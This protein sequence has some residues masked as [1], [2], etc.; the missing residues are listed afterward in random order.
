MGSA[1]VVTVRNTPI[2]LSWKTCQW[3]TTKTNAALGHLFTPPNAGIK[4]YF[5]I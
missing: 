4:I 1:F 2:Q 5:S 3:H